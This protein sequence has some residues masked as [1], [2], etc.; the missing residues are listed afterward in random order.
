LDIFGQRIEL[1]PELIAD[2]NGPIHSLNYD[3]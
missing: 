3:T 1:R 2:L